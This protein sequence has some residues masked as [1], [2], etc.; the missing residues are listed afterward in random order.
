MKL[1]QGRYIP[2]IV[3][4]ILEGHP[5]DI[6]WQGLRNFPSVLR[7]EKKSMLLELCLQILP[8]R[9]IF[10]INRR[11]DDHP[12]RALVCGLRNLHGNITVC[13]VHTCI[14]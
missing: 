5:Y 10:V 11:F 9:T 8:S 7:V 13:C 6:H 4:K 1:P 14:L 12:R 2:S 3:L